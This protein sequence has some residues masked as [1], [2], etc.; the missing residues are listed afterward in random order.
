ME[1]YIRYHMLSLHLINSHYLSVIV[2]HYQFLGFKS[3]QFHDMFPKIP[4]E[5]HETTMKIP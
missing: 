2:I 1:N 3:M 4:I 5:F